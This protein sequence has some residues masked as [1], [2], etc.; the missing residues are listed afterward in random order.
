ME[1]AQLVRQA[2]RGDQA[3][4][5][6]LT[7]RYQGMVYGYAYHQ[8]GRF[9]DA[10]DVTQEVFLAAYQTLDGL[11]QPD[12]FAGWLRG[13]AVN[14]CRRHRRAQVVWTADSADL[15]LWK[16]R[17]P[18]PEEALEEKEQGRRLERLLGALTEKNRLVVTLFYLEEMSYEEIGRF[19]GVP[20]STVKGRLHKARKRLEKEVMEMV[21]ES[22]ARHRLDETFAGQ[23]MKQVRIVE[24]GLGERRGTIWFAAEDRRSFVLAM[25]A[26]QAKPIIDGHMRN[27]DPRQGK[28][29]GLSTDAEDWEKVEESQPDVYDLV[30]EVLQ[31]GQL[32]LAGTIL[33]CPAGETLKAA[34][35]V[36]RE[37]SSRSIPLRVSDAL[38]LAQRLGKPVHAMCRVFAAGALSSGETEPLFQGDVRRQ[39][40]MAGRVRNFR[41]EV[42]GQALDEGVEQLRLV[43]KGEEVEVVFVQQGEE[44]TVTTLDRAVYEW[45]CQDSVFR[46]CDE[47]G[48]LHASRDHRRFALTA[49]GDQERGWVVEIEEKEAE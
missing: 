26:G 47:E 9:A 30:R 31:Q 21:K 23:V 11:R 16:D 44:R 33:D 35:V 43:P 34:A 3:A 20:V 45:V 49:S 6:T 15:A 4:F 12:R 32:E 39:I 7:R 14:H 42:I 46:R 38:I 18:D 28:G 24:T 25:P 2:R 27:Y 13:I 36:E 17:R 8:L 10:Q 48:H 1:D 19:L 22:F 40:E 41:Q 29:I 37:G 5:E